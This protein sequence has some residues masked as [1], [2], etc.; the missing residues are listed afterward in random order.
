M[1]KAT[2]AATTEQL[3]GN[4]E[5]VSEDL[6]MPQESHRE[7]LELP[8]LPVRNTVLL[9]NVVVPLLVGRDQSIKAIEYATS[10]DHNLFVVTQLHESLE[11]P[12]AEDLYTVGVEGCIDR[13]LKM[14]DGTMSI[15]LRGVRRL[16]RVEYT[17]HSPFMRVLAE[18]VPDDMDSTLALEALRRAALLLFEKCVKLNST[19]SDEA[20]I[21]GMNLD[22]PGLLADFIVSSL[23][24]PIPMRQDVLEA[25]NIEQRLQK[26]SLLLSK[27]LDIL[28]LETHIHNQIQQEVDK[29]QREYFLREQL[30]AIQ[31]ELGEGDPT[32]R[33][34][35]EMREQIHES[36]M[37]EAVKT[38][39]IKEL[40]RL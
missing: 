21:T 29:N 11:E 8:L 14:P 15:L 37:P 2:Q 18:V 7:I 20:Y 40:D 22:Q 25:F 27:E 26:V 36:T 12:D 10:N 30:K 35:L 32:L 23:E 24:I 6:G 17:Q 9:P 19:L 39:A 13:V 5:V 4:G 31:R 28:E 3:N 1:E 33:E 34:T 16:R 38:R